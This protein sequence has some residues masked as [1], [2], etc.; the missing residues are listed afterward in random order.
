MR[1][2]RRIQRAA[3]TNFDIVVTLLDRRTSVMSVPLGSVEFAV[4]SV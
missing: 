2:A 4:R 3:I 1:R